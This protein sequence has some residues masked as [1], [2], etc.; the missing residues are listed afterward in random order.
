M[1]DLNKRKQALLRKLEKHSDFI[2]GSINSVCAKC[3][4]ANCICERKASRKAYRLTYK[5]RN[6][7]TNIVYIPE[8]RLPEIRR[9]LANHHKSKLILDDI[10]QTNIEIFK[11]SR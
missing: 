6:Q 5:D 8:R 3:N 10:I 2:K 4:R 9:M 7:K 1:K 11:A